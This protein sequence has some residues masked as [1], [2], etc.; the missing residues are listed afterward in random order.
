MR[1]DHVDPE[2]EEGRFVF[3]GV[4]YGSM[5]WGTLRSGVAPLVLLH[6]FA[7]SASSWDEVAPCLARTRPVVALDL[8][9]HGCSDRPLDARRYRLDE[10]AAA[11]CAFL[12]HLAGGVGVPAVPV[13][14]Y[15]MG[16]RVALAAA[17]RDARPFAALVLESAG[18]GPVDEGER[19]QAAA[20][21]ACHAARLRSEGLE[22]FMD[23]WARLPLFVTQGE[24]PVSTQQRIRRG[25]LSND[26]EAL[27]RSFEGAGQHAMPLRAETLSSL[28]CFPAP[29]LYLAGGRDR[30]YREIAQDLR[31]EGVCAVRI[32]EG[33]G[34]NVHLEA[35]E[36][37]C[38]AISDFLANLR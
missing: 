31:A 19:A 23:D 1:R 9:G 18:L 33:A 20:R 27:A 5:R 22:A 37:F 38:A 12:E 34:H 4:T 21:D 7:Q 16:G 25:R 3:R 26:A 24:L 11:T 17:Q 29:V 30:T 6:G 13:V 8:V 15:S 36:R 32:V 28:A 14:G 2:L 35:P 10:A